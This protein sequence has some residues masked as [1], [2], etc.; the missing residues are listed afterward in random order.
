MVN[1]VSGPANMPRALLPVDGDDARPFSALQDL[2]SASTAFPVAFGPQPVAHCLATAP[3]GPG[4][5]CTP[6]QGTTALF[7]DGGFFDNQPLGLAVKAMRNGVAVGDGGKLG[8]VAHPEAG[9]LPDGA[10]FFYVDPSLRLTPTLGVDANRPP[11]LKL[12]PAALDVTLDLT[13]TAR[14]IHLDTL[15]QNEDAVRESLLVTRGLLPKASEPLSGFMG[16]FEHSF[17]SF[18]FYLGMYD[19]HRTLVERVLPR[20]SV[21][22][23]SLVHLPEDA[24]EAAWR[25]NAAGWKPYRC[26]RAVLD[27]EGDR[28]NCSGEDQQDFRI[29]LQYALERL[30]D[31]CRKLPSNGP[32]PPGT[33][34]RCLEAMAGTSPARVPFISTSTEGWR[35]QKGEG[36]LDHMLRRLAHHGFLFRDLGLT[37][38][39]ARNAKA[40]IRGMLS[41]MVAPL[42]SEQGALSSVPLRLAAEAGLNTLSYR[43]AR[44]LLHAVWGPAPEVGFSTTFPDS[45]MRWMRLSMALQMD[46]LDSV[47]S[48]RTTYVG[49]TPQAGLEVEPTFLSNAWAQP[50][51]GA[52]TGLLFSTGDAFSLR[53]CDHSRERFTPCSRV[54]LNGYASLSLLNAVRL[55]VAFQWWPGLAPGQPHLWSISPGVGLQLPLGI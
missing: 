21:L 23:R 52:R 26:L 2:L 24:P 11:S 13:N 16:F 9:E 12:L 35:S 45:M 37:R 49:L 14:S 31:E 22:E 20:L 48:S 55:Q 8:L 17:R 42:A 33:D 51:L 54:L 19:A 6:A 27:G 47:F 53:G 25:E 43:P 1:H 29:L 38:S 46:G 40:R 28:A 4:V 50:R 30:H 32:P 39:G 3:G 41:T 10:W 36:D 15:L 18:D 5:T 34:R 7:I 44:H